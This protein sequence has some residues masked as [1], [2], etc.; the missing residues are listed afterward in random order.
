MLPELKIT[1][2]VAIIGVLSALL[3][4]VVSLLGYRWSKQVV[5]S[6]DAQIAGLKEQVSALKDFSPDSVKKQS[7]AIIDTLKDDLSVVRAE[8]SATRS[9]LKEKSERLD[10]ALNDRAMNMGIAK[11]LFDITDYELELRRLC[12]FIMRGPWNP[13]QFPGDEDYGY[14]FYLKALEFFRRD[15]TFTSKSVSQASEWIM[16]YVFYPL[17]A[18]I[19]LAPNQKDRANSAYD[20]FLE[21]IESQGILSDQLQLYRDLKRMANAGASFD[22]LQQFSTFQYLMITENG[23][24]GYPYRSSM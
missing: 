9:K 8:L 19:A 1:E 24:D 23:D 4:A 15:P 22:E 18:C 12:S 6:K 20:D 13:R 14:E 11:S 21:E 16:D 7:Q 3:T 5:E 17:L 2:I 10:K